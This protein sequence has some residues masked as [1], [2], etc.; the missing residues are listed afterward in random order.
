MLLFIKVQ[1]L[2]EYS[3]YLLSREFKI[4]CPWELIYVDH[5]VSMA[6]MLEDLKK[7]LAIWKYNIEAKVLMSVL[8]EQNLCAAVISKFTS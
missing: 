6:E 1:Y 5:L 7:M 8:V 3:S 4:G 2:V